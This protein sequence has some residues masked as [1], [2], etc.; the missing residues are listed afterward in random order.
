M[1]DIELSENGKVT[2]NDDCWKECSSCKQRFLEKYWDEEIDW[3][4]ELNLSDE[5]TNCQNKPLN[6]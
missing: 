4:I 1:V 6:V 2:L 5:C 3:Y